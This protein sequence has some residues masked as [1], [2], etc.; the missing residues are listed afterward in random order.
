MTTSPT[1]RKPRTARSFYTS[2]PEAPPGKRKDR[3]VRLA[4]GPPLPEGVR[5]LVTYFNEA[6]AYLQPPYKAPAPNPDLLLTG[7]VWGSVTYARWLAP[8]GPDALPDG[9]PA[10]AFKI[11][12]GSP[13]FIVPAGF[14]LLRVLTLFER[15]R[16]EAPPVHGVEVLASG[17]EFTRLMANADPEEEVRLRGIH[18]DLLPWSLEIVPGHPRRDRQRDDAIRFALDGHRDS[19]AANLISREDYAALL[20]GVFRLF[21]AE[22]GAHFLRELQVDQG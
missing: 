18:A 9:G 21:D 17:F 13:R 20:K 10:I 3:R 5:D 4:Y 11:A 7:A 12:H 14:F 16:Y 8:D 6:V 22:H 2:E 19:S 15:E 1:L